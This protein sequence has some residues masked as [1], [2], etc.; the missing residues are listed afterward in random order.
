MSNIKTPYNFIPVSKAVVKPYW[1][2]YISHDIPFEDYQ[3]GEIEV[4]LEAKSPIFVKNG[5]GKEEE[6]SFYDN[7]KVQTRPYQFNQFQNKYF[8]PGAS[9]KGMIRSVLEIMSFGRMENKVNDTRYS[10]RDFHNK[11]IY[12]VTEISRDV[13]CGWLKKIGEEYHLK[14]CSKKPIRISYDK[15]DEECG[16]N[17]GNFFKTKSN[18]TPNTKSAKFKYDTFKNV[19]FKSKFSTYHTDFGI[20][21]EYDA[22]G[23]DGILVMTG[24]PGVRQQKNG[25]WSGKYHDFIFFN[26]NKEY[27]PVSEKVIENFF[28]AYYDHDINNQQND[29]KWRKPQLD[30]GEAIPVFFRKE[31]GEVKDMGLSMLYKITYNYSVKESVQNHQGKNTDYDLSEAI[32]GY[33]DEDKKEALKGRVHFGHAFSDNAKVLEERKEVLS[34]PKASYYPTYVRQEVN[35]GQVRN[36]K[37]FMDKSAVVAGW[38]RYPVLVGIPKTNRPDG[39]SEKVYTKFTPLKEGAIFKFKIRYHNLKKVE[40]GALLSALTFHQTE[41][42]FHSL[43]MAK[44]LG[45]GKIKLNIKNMTEAEMKDALCAYES[46]MNIELENDLPEWR[47]SSQITE[48]IAMVSEHGQNL[49]EGEPYIKLTDFPEMKKQ[50][51]GLDLYSKLINSKTQLKH[52]CTIEDIKSMQQRMEIEKSEFLNLRGAKEIIEDNIKSQKR[53]TRQLFEEKKQQLLRELAAKLEETKELERQQLVEK[54]QAERE[55]EKEKKQK[56]AIEEGINLD[57][58]DSN[59]RDAFNLLKKSIEDFARKYHNMNDKQLRDSFDDGILPE[60]AYDSVKEKVK[61]IFNDLKSKDKKKWL[62]PNSTQYKMFIEWMGKDEG[63]KLFD[64][65]N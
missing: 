2:K 26:S 34:G 15:I 48:L 4:T 36:Y 42:T 49:H 25:K 28:F 33:V 44:P 50:N 41:G 61:D 59:H 12:S 45:Y 18:I 62:K 47:T 60:L 35:N 65:L 64:I 27:K 52:F 23:E 8:I 32:F 30:R 20:R 24:Q 31:N 37:T 55:A 29:W 56:K 5:I 38:K 46:Y 58:I 1:A 40:L 7:N 9:I 21:G 19:K 39:V 53:L 54:E 22:N 63:H 13:Y 57:D 17:L 51:K 10:V 11:S 16:T 43:G 6:N 14:E 3:S